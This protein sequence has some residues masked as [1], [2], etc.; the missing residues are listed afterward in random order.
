MPRWSTLNAESTAESSSIS[1]H[2]VPENE[3]SGW[4]SLKAENTTESSASSAHAVPEKEATI[5]SKTQVFVLCIPARKAHAA[6]LMERWGLKNAKLVN[7]LDKNNLNIDALIKQGTVAPE[8]LEV[9]WH[10]VVYSP[11]GKVACH[12]GHLSI[13]ETFLAEDQFDFALIFE[14]DLEDRDAQEGGPAALQRD[15]HSFLSKVPR[16]FDLLHLGFVRE[17]RD[18]RIQADDAGEVFQS[19]EALGRHAYMVTKRAAKLLCQHTLPMY[20]HGDKMFQEVYQKYTIKAYQP[21][22]PLFYQDRIGFESELTD[23]WKP[24]RAFQPTANDDGIRARDR[25]EWLRRQKQQQTQQAERVQSAIRAKTA[26][27]TNVDG[28]LNR[29]SGLSKPSVSG[30]PDYGI[31]QQVAQLLRATQAVL[32]LTSSWRLDQTYAQ[33]LSTALERCGLPRSHMAVS[34][35]PDGTGYG[36]DEA[37]QRVM[38]IGAWLEENTWATSWAIADTVDLMSVDPTLEC[39]CVRTDCKVGLQR[40]DV[41]ELS[42]MLGATSPPPSSALSFMGYE[43]SSKGI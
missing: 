43:A 16:D 33:R 5:L 34:M 23:R 14:D 10:D 22:E 40:H 26:L 6:K 39:H 4:S 8:Y 17:S 20:N 35:T 12:L 18:A 29:I 1:S 19:V 9:L 30:R 28:V 13:L 41:I 42:K 15:L 25:S 32:V 7:G 31:L 36:A 24:S 21:R 11:E 27:F 2:A 37:E 38:E 3:A